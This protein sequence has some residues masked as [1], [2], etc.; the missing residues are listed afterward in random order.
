MIKLIPH[1]VKNLKTFWTSFNV[2]DYDFSIDQWK[3]IKSDLQEAC[4]LRKEA[5]R[6]YKVDPD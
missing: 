6:S 2:N 1:G 3:D 5:A 4:R